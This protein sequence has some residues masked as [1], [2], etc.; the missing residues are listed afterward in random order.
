MIPILSLPYSPLSLSYLPF[1]A[2]PGGQWQDPHVC[3]HQ[4]GAGVRLREPLLPQ[5]RSKGEQEFLDIRTAH[6]SFTHTHAHILRILH[7][8][9]SP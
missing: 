9:L 7:L 4:P 6:L 3:Q 8:T 1:A 2:M 5:V